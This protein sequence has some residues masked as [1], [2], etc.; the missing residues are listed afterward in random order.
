[1]HTKAL[2]QALNHGLILK[3]VYRVIQFNHE[4]WLKPY[5]DINTKL[6]KEAKNYFEKYFF[7]LMSNAVLGK[8]M[9]N[10]RKHRDIKLVTTDKRRNRLASE[11]SYHT[12]KY[13]S[14]NLTT[15]EMKNAK[16]KINKPIY[17]GM[18]ILDISKTFMYE[19]WYD[20]I[21]PKYQDKAQLCCMDTDSFVFNIKTEDSYKDIGNDAEKWFDTSNYDED[22]KRPLPIG[23]NKKDIALFKDELGGKIMKELV[24]LRANP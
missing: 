2:K 14:E 23:K 24:A 5:I 21:K 17:L 9:E 7:E 22:E 18:S 19:F 3:K 10:V 15:I 13:F 1:M 20:Y 8:T 11:P 6:R 4:A 16:V 12:T